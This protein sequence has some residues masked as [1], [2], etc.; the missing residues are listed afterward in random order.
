LVAF[1]VT[2]FEFVT[3]K[4]NRGVQV[5]V[6]TPPGKTEQGR[7]ALHVAKVV[8]EFY[9]SK[10]G[11]DYPL[12]KSDLIAVPDFQGSLKMHLLFC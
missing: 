10:F 9:E 7:Y 4:T 1:C 12:P 6:W 3:D 5:S 11:V 8:L 2:N